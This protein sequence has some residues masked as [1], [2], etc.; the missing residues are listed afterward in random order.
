MVTYAGTSNVGRSIL[1]VETTL[2]NIFN[3]LLVMWKTTFKYQ[4]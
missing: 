1:D 2:N 3:R 4:C